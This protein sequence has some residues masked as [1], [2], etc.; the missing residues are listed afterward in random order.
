[1]IYPFPK[2]IKSVPC[3]IIDDTLVNS[4]KLFAYI[5]N[6][7]TENN[8]GNAVQQQ[9]NLNQNQGNKT[10]CSVDEITG[11]CSGGS[12]LSFSSIDDNNN[13]FFK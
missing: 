6:S 9:Q 12:C 4:E 5:L 2:A 1:M 3:M 7:D 8:N 13:F 10:E 11:I